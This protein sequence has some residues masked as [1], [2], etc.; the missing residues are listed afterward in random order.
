VAVYSSFA[1]AQAGLDEQVWEL[2]ADGSPLR[3]EGTEVQ[4][5]TGERLTQTGDRKPL[6]PATRQRHQAILDERRAAVVADTAA[7][8]E[9]TD[10]ELD[11]DAESVESRIEAAAT[12]LSSA[13]LPNLEVGNLS[14]EEL[15]EI[16]VELDKLINDHRAAYSAWA[17]RAERWDASAEARA[18]V[19]AYAVAN[20]LRLHKVFPALGLHRE[21]PLSFP[22]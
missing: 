6:S 4:L 3:M 17:N 22:W 13:T 2:G 12:L 10:A 9:A 15:D 19:E 21:H 1:A 16:T 7:T 20:V 11:A 8:F 14:V 18:D 5:P